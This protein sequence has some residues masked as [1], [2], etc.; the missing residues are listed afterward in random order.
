MGMRLAEGLTGRD[1]AVQRVHAA[2]CRIAKL[3]G[4]LDA[5][6]LAAL[7]EAK[8]LQ[9]W[10]DFGYATIYEYLEYVLGHGPRVAQERLRVAEA[11]EDLPLIEEALATG[12]AHYSVVRELTRVASSQTEERWL[13]RARDMNVRQ[14]EELVQ[15]HA[16]G[17][18]PD[19]PVDPKIRR[20][21]LSYD[22]IEAETYAMERQARVAADTEQGCRLS[23]DEFL[24]TLLATYLSG[25]ANDNVAPRPAYQLSITT[26]RECKRSWQ[27]G[28]GREVP[29]DDKT[30][31][32]AS[33][34]ATIIGALDAVVPARIT[35][36]VTPRVRLQVF[37]RDNF[38]CV[39]PGCR[40]ARNLQIHHL[41]FQARGGKHELWNMCTACFGHHKL[42]H[43]GLFAISGRA[44]DQLVFE[45][46]PR[47]ELSQRDDGAPLAPTWAPINADTEHRDD[48]P[49]PNTP[50]WAQVEADAERALVSMGFR[51]PEAR[52]AVARASADADREVTLE[53][54]VRDALRKLAPKQGA[55]AS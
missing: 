2:L 23:D 26:C 36:T 31:E 52:Q 17:D 9:L 1:D 51:K 53:T 32:R 22:D 47:R 37:T 6:E 15:G 20:H 42:L 39:V 50:T 48:E 34:D 12:A 55:G 21:R 18:D 13:D 19:D 40:S 8:E 46:R 10:R 5:Q 24:H 54:L 49:S 3:R 4:P 41:I 29:I 7:R 16:Y 38:R 35:M 44:P 25:A 14:V 45:Q 43:D 30:V 28:G 27:N 11:L 33:C